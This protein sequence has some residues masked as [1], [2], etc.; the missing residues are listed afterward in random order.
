MIER[1]RRQINRVWSSEV[2][3]KLAAVRFAGWLFTVQ[4]SVECSF[5]RT[6]LTQRMMEITISRTSNTLQTATRFPSF[7]RA[8]LC[9]GKELFRLQ[10]AM[11]ILFQINYLEIIQKNKTNGNQ[12]Y[13]YLSSIKNISKIFRIIYCTRIKNFLS[14][15]SY[16]PCSLKI[17][18]WKKCKF[19]QD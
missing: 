6:L 4:D 9:R 15:F 18:L 10:I 13:F 12:F 1:G 8:L 14:T 7:L 11:R 16:P 5:S 3:I 19:F 17:N 2:L